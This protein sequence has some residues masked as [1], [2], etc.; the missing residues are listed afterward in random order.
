MLEEKIN[1]DKVLWYFDQKK[2]WKSLLNITILEREG[3]TDP[4]VYDARTVLCIL[5]DVVKRGTEY[6]CRNFVNS[7]ALSFCFAATSLRSDELRAFAFTILAR[8]MAK[9]KDLSEEVFREG[10]QYIYLIY[11]FKNS[12]YERNQRVPHVVSHFF[13]RVSKLL[14]V[15]EDEVFTPIMAFLALKPSIDLQ[16]VPEFLKLFFSGSTDNFRKERHHVVECCQG[17]FVTPIVDLWLKLDI[18][19]LFDNC[20]QHETVAMDFFIR[21]NF[22]AWIVQAIEYERTTDKEEERLVG[23]FVQII[24]Q[25]RHIQKMAE[26]DPSDVDRKL[27]RKINSAKASLNPQLVN[28]VIRVNAERALIRVRKWD[29]NDDSKKWKTILKKIVKKSKRLNEASISKDE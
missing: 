26:A 19:K 20:V 25:I 6:S 18:L 7:N 11:I 9:L 17:L 29:E 28:A 27:R 2:M 15:P 10:Q 21:L 24:N 1:R 12:I 4:E 23:I 5:L 8:Y 16:M 3:R 22:L 14:M 13:A